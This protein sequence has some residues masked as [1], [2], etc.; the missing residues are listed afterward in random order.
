MAT[1]TAS[2]LS[3]GSGPRLRFSALAAAYTDAVSIRALLSPLGRAPLLSMSVHEHTYVPMCAW[4]PKPQLLC[5]LGNAITSVP[6][7]AFNGL[8]NLE[9]LDLSKNNITS[10]GI[11]A[12]AFKVNTQCG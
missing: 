12:K 5:F 2:P 1:S 6:D 4:G 11:G 3:G 9:R 10:A 8:P 7:G